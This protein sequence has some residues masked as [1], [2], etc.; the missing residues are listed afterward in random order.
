MKRDIE[1]VVAKA[2]T[3]QSP[4]EQVRYAAWLHWGSS[5]GLALLVI[6]FVVHATAMLEPLIPHPDLPRAWTMSAAEMLR[7]TGQS[8]GWGWVRL[9]DR[10]DILNLAA[11]ALLASCSAAPLLAVVPIYLKRRERLFAALC[12]LQVAV[13][14]LAASGLVRVGH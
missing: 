12:L 7:S 4:P 8:P 6:A 10:S 1:A 11:I 3:V 13:L 5:L 2:G 9:L 14:A